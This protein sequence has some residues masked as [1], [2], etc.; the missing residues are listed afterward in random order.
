MGTLIYG[1]DS[2]TFQF[3]DRTLAHVRAVIIGKFRRQESFA[4]S[5]VRGEPSNAGRECLWLHPCIALRFSFDTLA[6]QVGP[7]NREW[8]EALATSA[9]GGDMKIVEEPAPRTGQPA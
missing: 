5:F 9:N 7:L 1:P 8:V 4:L 2:A 6:A 3:D